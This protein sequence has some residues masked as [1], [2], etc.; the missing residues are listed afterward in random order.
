MYGFFSNII[1]VLLVIYLFDVRS[2]LADPAPITPSGLIRLF[3]GQTLTNLYPWFSG[4]G[5]SDPNQ[6]FRVENGL[7]HVT[8]N[9]WGALTTSNRY[10]DYVMIIEFKWGPQ[11]W[12][13]REGA[14]KDAGILFHSN[15][16]EGGWQGKLIPS[17]QAQMMEGSMGDIILM[18]STDGGNVPISFVAKVGQVPDIGHT[19]NYRGGYRWKADG[20]ARA[21]NLNLDSVHWSD[22]DSSWTDVIGFRGNPDIENPDGQWNQMVVIAENNRAEIYFNGVKVNELTNVIPTEGKIQ[23]E[24]EFAEFFVRRWEL[25]PLG[26]PFVD[27][28]LRSLEMIDGKIRLHY[29]ELLSSGNYHLH[30]VTNLATQ[31]LSN[32]SNRVHTVTKSEIAAMDSTNRSNVIFESPIKPSGEFFQLFLETIP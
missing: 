19:W 29:P 30:A 21:F 31:V 8:G 9:G 13:P 24:V 5:F 6:V 3:D 26:S 16:A 17:I 22:W 32:I 10:R 1:A 14:A 4:S 18:G 15:G 23:L 20:T 11:T 2:G 12:A 28:K 25:R 27:L 7:L